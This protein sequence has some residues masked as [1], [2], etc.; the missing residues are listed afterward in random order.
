[1]K[2]GML[3]TAILRLD[4]YRQMRQEI[5][6][7]PFYSCWYAP[8]WLAS[9]PYNGGFI[10]PLLGS[11]IDVYLSPILGINNAAEKPFFSVKGSA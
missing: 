5:A 7:Q 6:R 11:V 9:A 4:R 8:A 1:M 2:F 3:R 10:I